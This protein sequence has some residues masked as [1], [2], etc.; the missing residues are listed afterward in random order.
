MIH[1]DGEP[2]IASGTKGH[3]LASVF[4]IKPKIV[5]DAISESVVTFEPE[6]RLM[7]YAAAR[8]FRQVRTLI[9]DGT[10][11]SLDSVRMFV[12]T[13]EATFEAIS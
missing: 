6:E 5:E 12:S 1:T 13:M 4:G 9:E 7:H 2:T 11:D 10:L 3:R 8:S